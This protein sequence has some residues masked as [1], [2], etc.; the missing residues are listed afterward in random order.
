MKTL[1]DTDAPTGEYRES[2][3]AISPCGVYRYDLSRT[4][5]RD[6]PVCLWIMVNP[7][8]ADAIEPDNTI[9]RCVGFARSWGYGGIV[10]GNLFAV[11][12]KNVR[13]L[14]THPDPVGPDND[15][16]LVRLANSAGLTVA[17]WGSKTGH[18]GKLIAAR[19]VVVRGMFA[20]ASRP[21]HYL[22]LGGDGQPAHPLMLPRSLTPQPWEG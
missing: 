20:D 7:S 15:A 2:T 4:W 1:F 16:A 19:A 5:N 12:D 18:L 13:V 11:R 10:V 22:R 3:A 14:L 6:K 21:L 8:T 9:K 17:A